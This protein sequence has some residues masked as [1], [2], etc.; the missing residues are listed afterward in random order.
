ML[1]EVAQYRERRGLLHRLSGLA[2]PLGAQA[3]NTETLP[4]GAQAR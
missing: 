2:Q 4:T 1:G 3:V